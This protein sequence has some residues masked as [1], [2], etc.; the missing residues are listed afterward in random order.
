ML[1]AKRNFPWLIWMFSFTLRPI[2]L[3]RQLGLVPNHV[4]VA[5]MSSNNPSC[6]AVAQHPIGLGT[7]NLERDQVLPALRSAILTAGYRRIDCAPVYF[8]EDVIGD[9]LHDILSSSPRVIQREDLFVVSKLPSALHRNVEAA[10][11]KS[12]SDLRLDYLDLYLIHWPV[13]FYPVAIHPGRGWENEDIDDS[14]G[15]KRIDPR[16]SVHDTWRAM[17]DL[18]DM[19]LVR[20]IGVSN[21]PVMLLHELLSR[22]PRI[23]PAVNQCEAHPYLQQENLLHYC[24]KRG[25]HFQAYSPLGTPGY[26][27]THEP[28]LLQDPVLVELA[29]KYQVSPAQICLAWALQRGTSVVAKSTSPEHQIDNLL[30]TSS[31]SSPTWSLSE[32]DMARIKGINRNY[33]F[34]R[35]EEWWSDMAM[36]VFD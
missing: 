33:R 24:Q 3:P 6:D 12:L 21:F 34:F 36:A 7:L 22:D 35:P 18:V 15:G 5:A 19:G 23:P 31:S 27:E 16:V 10:V 20:H 4:L 28:A 30:I 17:E 1:L 2:S 11:R 25:I 26:K 13:A 32:E 14:D 9:A 8:N 29:A